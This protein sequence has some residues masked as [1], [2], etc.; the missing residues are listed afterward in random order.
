[1]Y[2]ELLFEREDL[3]FILKKHINNL[4]HLL[5]LLSKRQIE[6]ELLN[7]KDLFERY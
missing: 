2:T 1:M 5:P 7:L 6:E 4:L 3:E